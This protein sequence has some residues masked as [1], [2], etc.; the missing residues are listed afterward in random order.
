MLSTTVRET[1]LFKNTRIIL[2]RTILKMW[3][4]HNYKVVGF[5]KTALIIFLFSLPTLRRYQDRA[6]FVEIMF[7]TP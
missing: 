4:L 2:Y 1:S 7:K 5:V 6:Y 3:Y